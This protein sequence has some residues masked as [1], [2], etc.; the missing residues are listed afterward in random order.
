MQL[1]D[2]ALRQLLILKVTGLAV[3]ACSPFR[4]WH[5]YFHCLHTATYISSLFHAESTKVAPFHAVNK[6]SNEAQPLFALPILPLL[7]IFLPPLS[8]HVCLWNKCALTHGCLISVQLGT[9]EGKR[10]TTGQVT[11]ILESRTLPGP[12][13]STEPLPPPPASH[14][15]ILRANLNVCFRSTCSPILSI[16]VP[17]PLQ[18]NA[19]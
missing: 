4:N 11:E 3:I 7:L 5:C 17:P 8:F 14:L 1:T 15:G 10:M 16:Q 13:S 12:Q 6:S 2:I 9:V 19:S 18:S